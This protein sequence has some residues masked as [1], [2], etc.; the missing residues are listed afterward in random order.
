MYRNFIYFIVALLI[1]STFQPAEEPN[2][3]L[4][5]TLAYL[6]A[7]AAG[8]VF[9]GW[10]Q[11]RRFE[12]RLTVTH[13]SKRSHQFN[14]L[15][16]RQIILAVFI[17]AI[18][19]YGLNVSFYTSR[20]FL[21]KLIPTLEAAMFLLLFMAYLAVTWALA[22]RVHRRVF[23]SEITARAYVFSNLMF[24]IPVLLPWFLLSL[25]SDLVL[26]LPFQIPKY[27]L[28][29]TAGQISYF[30]L[31][32]FFVAL[33]GP[34]IIQRFWRCKPLHSGPQRTHIEA[35]CGRAGLRYKDILLW[36]IFE[37]RMITAG[38]MGLVKQF[39]YIL[40]T[41]SLLQRLTPDEIEAVVAHEIGHVKKKHL[42]FYLIFFVGY[43]LISYALFDLIVYAM[44][45]LNPL[46]TWIYRLGLDQ[47][48]V[49]PAIFSLVIIATFLFYFRFI[50]GY[51]MRNF[52]R[53]ADIFVFDL[54]GTAAPL[55]ST[56][57]K[58]AFMSGE[59]ADKPNWHHFSI[60]ERI[61]YLKRCHSDPSWIPRH[62]TKVKRGIVTY[63]LIIFGLA[64]AGFQL[65]FGEAGRR[66]D[67]HFYEKIIL[68][69]ISRTPE[70]ADLYVLLGDFYY[71]REKHHRASR[72]YEQ[73][74]SLSATHSRALNNL[75]W[76]YATTHQSGLRDPVRALELAERAAFVEQA[77]H[78]LDTLAECYFV[79]NRISDAIRAE[80]RALDSATANRRYYEEQLHRFES[81]DR[82]R[83]PEPQST[84]Q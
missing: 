76:L 66:L 58:I 5:E 39:R 26:V 53:Q 14:I 51:F 12:T 20:F 3:N 71:G 35:L 2:F 73:A 63:L 4:P 11:F 33:F 32:L 55:V 62:H 44:I 43:M 38:V 82:G 59:P 30:L 48:T 42:L 45:Y 61:D 65:S 67:N 64:T 29:T 60:Q 79:N 23:H 80:Q 21:F 54:L 34:A 17:F 46:I 75:A 8:Y 84:D 68:Q 15:L 81:E 72:A 1:Y 7:F 83:R 16:N 69:E 74:V 41:R 19:V 70:N 56:L 6:A 31:F 36:P 49:L 47:A 57:E 77:P 9:L 25:V 50:F 27:I 10:V 37:G 40:V 24:S 28:S 18:D 22:H 78:I 52:E 13:I